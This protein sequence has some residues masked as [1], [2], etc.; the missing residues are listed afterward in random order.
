MR[1][2]YVPQFLQRPWTGTDRKL[3]VF[4]RKVGR[5]EPSRQAPKGN[6][7]MEDML[8]LT[9]DRVAGMDRH[10]IERVVLQ[11]VDNDASKIRDKLV[12]G[13]INSL[14]GEERESWVRFLIT[15][16]LR[17]PNVVSFIREEAQTSLKENLANAPED[18][19]S[20]V[21]QGVL[22]PAEKLVEM[23][24]PGLIA[25][26]G[27]RLF[28][29]LIDYKDVNTKLLSL[30]WQ[31]YDFIGSKNSLLLSDNPCITTSGIEHPDLA[32]ILPISP[33]KAFI[34]TRGRLTADAVSGVD[35]RD[36]IAHVNELSLKQAN[37]RV[38]ALDES[39]RRYIENRWL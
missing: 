33:F 36:L 12:A 9:E 19:M 28:S 35:M 10:D 20:L 14:S 25:N 26:Y 11:S 34:A 38:F 13:R 30:N 22:P 32:V 2:H 27:L 3:Q 24:V 7:Y 6:G 21:I 29:G 8:A 18:Y 23:A 15:L 31:V 4:R 5:V 39:P 1:N 16:R 37:D 17:Q